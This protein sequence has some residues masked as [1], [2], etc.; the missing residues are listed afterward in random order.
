MKPP[1]QQQEELLAA[2]IEFQQ[3]LK[4]HGVAGSE[5]IAQAVRIAAMNA[6]DEYW[7]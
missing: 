1:K 3:T 2:I 5:K 4:E 7:S 6:Q